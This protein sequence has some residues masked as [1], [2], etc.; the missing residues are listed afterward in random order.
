MDSLHEINLKRF[1]RTLRKSESSYLNLIEDALPSECK[2]WTTKD[3]TNLLDCLSDH[4]L[5]PDLTVTIATAF[6]PIL[7][8]LLERAFQRLLAQRFSLER[9][10]KLCAACAELLASFPDANTFIQKYLQTAPPVF[11]RLL[12]SKTKGKTGDATR[13][14]AITTRR[15]VEHS[16]EAYAGQWDWSPFLTLLGSKDAETRWHAT[17]TV[18]LISRMGGQC[19]QNF[20]HS[21]FK[22]E[23]IR[24][25]QIS[26]AQ[27]SMKA[28][29]LVLEDLT[30][31]EER[32]ETEMDTGHHLMSAQ[33]FSDAVVSVHGVLLPKLVGQGRGKS[34][35]HRLVPVPSTSRNLRSLALAVST[36]RAVLLEGPVGCGKTA[37]VEHLA[38][39]TGRT[40]PPSLTK[41]QLGDQTDSKA[42]L[43]TYRC[44]DI[45]GEFVWQPGALTQAV[46]QGHWI[47]LEDIDYAPMDVISVLL[48]LLESRTL[49]VPGH[50]NVI[51]AAPGFRLFATQRLLSSSG[52]LYRQQV[53]HGAMLDQL[54]TRVHVEPLSRDELHQVITDLY[55]KLTTVTSKLLNIYC[56]LTARHQ[57]WLD[58]PHSGQE[59]C[60]ETS[61]G[62]STS[63]SNDRSST[64]DLD[65]RSRSQLDL[66]SHGMR[67]VSTR[68]LIKWCE[69]IVTDFEANSSHTANRVFLEALDCFCGSLTTPEMRATVAE[70]IG[71]QVNITREKARFY[72]MTY[73]PEVKD[74]DS[75]ITA[76]RA[77]L[78]RKERDSMSRKMPRS[79]KF[80]FTRPAAVL[81]ERIACCI[82]H[83]EPVL[84]V[85]ET[86][87]GKTSTV[88]YLADLLGQRLRVINMNQQ[89]DSTDLL[90]GFKPVDLRQ[91]VAPVRE[92]FEDA[93]R[94]TFS[95]KQNLQFLSHIQQCFTQQRWRELVQ[96][97]SHSQQAA[98]KRFQRSHDK[99]QAGASKKDV[100][101]EGQWR[102]LGERLHQLTIQIQHSENALAFSFIE[103]TLVKALKAGDWILLD[104]I[105]LATAETLECLSSLLEGTEGS[106]VLMERGDT[107]PVVR[108]RDFRLFA[109]MN[110]ATDVGK[111]ELP[112]G[113]RNRFTEF[114]VDELEEVS[115]LQILTKSYLRA[116]SITEAQVKGIVQFYLSVR[117]EA[118]QKLTDGTGHRPHYSL[119]TLCR[120]LQL[121]SVNQCD[122]LPR[123]LYESF[124]LSFLT[125]L[126][127]TSHPVV[128]KL[129]CRHVIGRSNVKSLLG[130]SIPPPVGGGKYTKV[131]GY[132]VAVGEREPHQPKDYVITPAVRANLRDL[133]RIVSAG[134]FPVL[135]QGE[136]SVGKTSLVNYLA[137]LTG[138]HCV[139]VNNHEHTDLQE[140]IGFYAAD[141]SGKLVFK[142]GVLVDAMRRGHW[143]I[144]DE[145]NLAPS[146]VLEAL[147]RLLDDNRE[148]F[149]P[150]TQE[151][152]SA[153]PKF[154]LFATQNPP[155]QYGG[156][157]VLSRAFRN[158]FIE[159]HFDEIPSC[160]LETIL[161]DRCQ[162][163]ASYSRKMVAIMLELQMRRKGSGVFA[164][165]QGFITL[166][167]LF[168]WAERYRLANQGDQS[169][170]DWNQHLADEGFILLAGRV[171]RAEE[172]DTIRQV[173]Q[174]HFKRVVN[175]DHLFTLSKHTSPVTRDIL[176]KVSATTPTGFGHIVWTYGM[177]RL[178]V[179][180]GQALK[181]SEP[182]LLVGET[183][184]GKTTVCQLFAALANHKL[185]VVNCH[186]H[187]E[188][189]DFLGGLRPVRHHGNNNE[190]ESQKLFEWC[191]GPL[192]EAMRAG[193]IFLIDEISLADDSVLERLNSVLEPERTLLLAERG[194]GEARGEEVPLIRAEDGFRVVATMN[195]GGDFG[196][197]ELSP[198]LRNRF[199]E[200]WCT[201][202]KD[203]SDLVS[204]I[205]HN[206]LEGVQLCNQQDGTSGIG[207]AV[208]DFIEWFTNNEAGRK[209][210]VSI[211]DILS[212]VDFINV[213]CSPAKAGSLTSQ[214][215]LLP[216]DPAVAFIHG[217]CMVFVDGLGSG[218]TS[219]SSLSP[220]K[221]RQ[222][223]LGRLRDQILQ[224]TGQDIDLSH[225]MVTSDLVGEKASWGCASVSSD[226][227]WFGVEPFYIKCGPCPA[228]C[229]GYTL[230]ASTTALNAQ[231]LL[232]ALQLPRAV[233]LEG[234]P[235]VGKTSLVSALAR[236]SG[237]DLVRINLS[238]QT[239]ITDLFGADL[240]VEGGEGGQFAWRDGP[241]LQALKA[242]HWVVLDELN[243]ASQSVLEGL[244]A[245]LDHRAEIFVPELGRSFQIRQ[246][247]T[248]LFAC[249][250]PLRQGGGRKG[251][252]KSFLN[253][254]TQVYIEPFTSGDLLFITHSMYPM[255]DKETLAAMVEFSN[256]LYRETMVEGRWGQRG[257]PWEF[258]LRDLF[259]WCDLMVRDL[260]A[261]PDWWDP[262][263]HVGLVYGDRMRTAEDKE[264]VYRLYEKVLGNKFGGQQ[265]VAYRSSR[266]FHITPAWLQVG[267]AFLQR[268][269]SSGETSALTQVPLQLLHHDLGAMESIMK[270]VEMNWM[271]ILVGP[272]SSGKTSLVHLLAALTGH[273]LQVLAMNSA[274]DTT[275]L[276]GGFEQA[277][278]N[279]HWEALV[280]MVDDVAMETVR[281]LLTRHT[282]EKRK[283]AQRIMGILSALRNST[284][285]EQPESMQ[286]SEQNLNMVDQLLS[287]LNSAQV[288]NLSKVMEA[289][290]L[291]KRKYAMEDHSTPGGGGRFE[292]VDGLLVQALKQGDWLL[293]DNVN[294]CSPSVLDRLNGLLEP[295]G[296]LTINER[297]VIDGDI[298]AIKPHPEFRLFLAMDPR[299]GEISRAMRNRGVE[300]Y[301]LGEMEGGG[302]SNQDVC[303]LL[304]AIGL[305]SD[306]TCSTLMALHAEMRS[307]LHGNDSTRLPSLL[308]AASKTSR[309]VLNGL[310]TDRALREACSE[311]YVSSQL[312]LANKQRAKEALE[313]CLSGESDGI[314]S[315]ETEDCAMSVSAQRDVPTHLYPLTDAR[316][317][318]TSPSLVA[319]Q[320]Q[321]ALLVHLLEQCTHEDSTRSKPAQ[322]LLNAALLLFLEV[323]SQGDWELRCEWLKACG[324]RTEGMHNLSSRV[325]QSV[326]SHPL[327]DKIRQEISSEQIQ[328]FIL[329]PTDVHWN[330]QLLKSLKV[331]LER[332]LQDQDDSMEEAGDVE[333][334]VS[335][336]AQLATRLFLVMRRELAEALIAIEA[337]PG[338]KTKRKKP[339]S[340]L[341]WSNALQKGWLSVESLPHP[342]VSHV[343]PFLQAWDQFV[344]QGLAADEPL[345][346]NQAF[347]ILV[348][349]QWRDRLVRFCK[350]PIRESD[351]FSFG[352][353]ALHWDWFLKQTVR[354]V[355]SVLHKTE[356]LPVD[357]ETIMK[358][359]HA[360]LDEGGPSTGTFDLQLWERLT[361]SQ[362][363]PLPFQTAAQAQTR[364]QVGTLCRAMD[365]VTQAGGDTF[366]R[367]DVADRCV[368]WS[369]C[370]D[371]ALMRKKLLQVLAQSA[372]Y[373][374][375]TEESME[376]LEA[377]ELKLAEIG[378][379]TRDVTLVHGGEAFAP[380]P[381]SGT[382]QTPTAMHVWLWPIKE[383][384]AITTSQRVVSQMMGETFQQYGEAVIEDLRTLC[385][386]I[387]SQTPFNPLH[388]LPLERAYLLS[389][390]DGNGSVQGH[391]EVVAELVAAQLGLTWS[392][393]VLAMENWLSW[394]PLQEEEDD[395]MHVQQECSA[396]NGPANFFSPVQA[397]CMF[398]LLSD[399]DRAAA[400]PQ[401]RGARDRMTS[402]ADDGEKK[403]M[404]K[405]SCPRDGGA[406]KNV[407]LE[408][409][410]AYQ[411]H[412][413]ELAQILW[414][415][416]GWMSSKQASFL[417]SSVTYLVN[418][419]AWLLRAFASILQ[420]T[421]D[422][423]TWL[424]SCTSLVT[425]VTPGTDACLSHHPSPLDSMAEILR[426]NGG[427]SQQDRES[428]PLARDEKGGASKMIDSS[429]GLMLELFSG[430]QKL[431]DGPFSTNQEDELNG[432]HL[433]HLFCL[434]QCWVHLGHLQTHLLAPQGP[435]DPAERNAIKLEYVREELSDIRA[436]LRGRSISSSL[437]TGKP[438]EE[439]EDHQVHPRILA[440]QE[441]LKLLEE[442]EA[443]LSQKDAFRPRPP[444]FENLLRD[445]QLYLSSSGSSDSIGGLLHKLSHAFQE[446]A[447]DVSMAMKEER[448]WQSSQEHFV[449]RLQRDYPAYRDLWFGFAAGVMGA[450]YG[451]RLM[452]HSVDCKQQ[453][454]FMDALPP[455]GSPPAKMNTLEELLVALVGF[456]ST[457]SS[458]F[459]SSHSLAEALTTQGVHS[460]LQG[461][462]TGHAVQPSVQEQLKHSILKISLHHTANHARICGRLDPT[463][464]DLLQ[465]IL[466]SLVSHYHQAEQAAMQREEEEASLYKYKT[467]RHGDGM[468][469]EQKEEREL[470]E[471]F[472]SFDK[473]FNDLTAEPS[474]DDQPPQDLDPE[475]DQ[476]GAD[477][478]HSMIRQLDTAT[479]WLLRDTHGQLF[480]KMVSAG[481]L[482]EQGDRSGLQVDFANI[483][484]MGYS[485]GVQLAQDVLPFMAPSIDKHLVGAHLMRVRDLQVSIATQ[486]SDDRFKPIR[487][488]DGDAMRPYNIYHDPNIPEVVQCKSVLD[489]FTVRIDEL[490]AEWPD[491]PT[492]KQL[493]MLIQRIK[494]F[495]VNSPLMQFVTGLELLLARSQEWEANASRA[496]SLQ[497][498]LERIT[499]T[500]IR[501][502]KLELNCWAA[503]LD[504]VVYRQ[505]EGSL[506]WWFY[507]YRLVQS[508]GHSTQSDAE[509]TSDGDIDQEEGM[510]QEH[511]NEV[512]GV[513][514]YTGAGDGEFGQ[515]NECTDTIQGV[516]AVLQKLIEGANLGEFVTRV[517]ML[518]AFHC[519]LVAGPCTDKSLELMC[520]LWNLY[521]YYQQFL[522][523]VT[524]E[525]ENKRRPIEKELKDFVKI[526]KWNDISFWA[527][528]QAVEKTHKTLLKFSKKFQCALQE[529]AKAV[530]V[531]DKIASCPK[532]AESGVTP[533][534][535]RDDWMEIFGGSRNQEFLEVSSALDSLKLLYPE[536][537][538]L[539]RLP[540]L[541]QRMVKHCRSVVRGRGYQTMVST[542]DDFV[543]E[544]ISTLS[545]L[546]GLEVSKDADQEK[547][548]K[549][550]R[551]IHLR[552]RKALSELFKYL[553]SLGLSFK[554]GLM[555]R[556]QTNKDQ[557][558][559][560]FLLL[561]PVDLQAV[562]RPDEE[563]PVT[564]DDLPAIWA[565]GHQYFF[566][567]QARQAA[568]KSAIANP[569]KELGV[570][571][572]D[573]VKGFSEHLSD[574]TVEQRRE[575][576]TMATNISSLRTAVQQ[577]Q[578]I[579]TSSLSSRAVNSCSLPPQ[580]DTAAWIAR[581]KVMVDHSLEAVGQFDLLMDCCPRVDS[582]GEESD[583]AMSVPVP[584]KNLSVGS[585]CRKEDKVWLD[586]KASVKACQD[587][588]EETKSDLDP[589][590]VEQEGTKDPKMVTFATWNDIAVLERCHKKL[591]QVC[592][593]ITQVVTM[594]TQP[595]TG[596][597][598]QLVQSLVSISCCLSESSGEWVAWMQSLKAQ[599]FDTSTTQG[600]Q[601][602][603][604]W[605]ELPKLRV[606]MERAVTS[607]LLGIQAL[608]K[609]GQGTEVDSE[610]GTNDAQQQNKQDEDFSSDLEL[611]G[612]LVRK[613]VSGLSG[614][615]RSLE[616]AKVVTSAVS[617]LSV[618]HDLRGRC[619]TRQDEMV[620]NEC[621]KLAT[622]LIPMMHQYLG[623][624]CVFLRHMVAAHRA[625]SK[626]QSV[627]LAIFT[628]LASKG[629]CLPAEYSDEVG[630]EGATEF[631][632]IEGG[633]IGEGEGVKD[634]SDQIENEDQVEDTK[635]PGKEEKEKEDPNNQPDLEDEEHGIEMSDDFEGKLHDLDSKEGDQDQDE[636]QKDEEEQLDKQMGDVDQPDADKLD[637]RMWG[638]EEEE[639][640]DGEKEQKEQ[641]KEE[642]FGGGM[643]EEESRMVAKDDNQGDG[644][645]DDDNE[646]KK[647]EKEK[648]EE[649]PPD[650]NSLEPKD[651]SEFNDDEIDP[652]KAN[653]PPVAPVPEELDLPDDLEMDKDEKMEEGEEE[654]EGEENPLDIESKLD[655]NQEGEGDEN[656]GKEEE[657]D[658]EEGGAE[659]EKPEEPVAMETDEVDDGDEQERDQGKE[660]E[661]RHF[662]DK[663][664]TEGMDD[665]TENDDKEK[666]EDYAPDQGHDSEQQEAVPETMA[667]SR[668]S[669]QTLQP[670]DDDDAKNETDDGKEE[671]ATSA[672]DRSEDKHKSGTAER[673]QDEK[674]HEGSS[675]SKMTTL[676]QSGMQ[677]QQQAKK[678]SQSDSK[679]SLGSAEEKF[680]R[681]LDTV[682][683]GQGEEERTAEDRDEVKGE[684]QDLYEHLTDPTSHHDAQT[685]DAAT[686]DQMKEKEAVPMAGEDDGEKM[687][688]GDEERMEAEPDKE[689]E[690]ENMSDQLPSKKVAA[691]TGLSKLEAP[692]ADDRDTTAE[693]GDEDWM[694]P[695]DQ[696]ESDAMAT[697]GD[698]ERP[699]ESTI[700][701]AM[702]HLG[703]HLPDAVL[704][705]EEV[706]RLRREME[707]QL[708]LIG[709]KESGDGEELEAQ[710]MWQ[711]YESVT[712]ALARDLCEQL[713]LV[714]EPTQAS[715]LRGDFRT[716]K[717]LNMRKVI[718]YIASGFRKD[719]IW[720]RRTKP[721]KR[722]YQIMLAVDDS[723]SMADNRSR[724]LAFE[725]LAVISN[726]LTWLEAGQLAVCSFGENVQ[727]LHP[728]HEQFSEQSGAT[729][730]RQFTFAQKKTKIAQLLKYASAAMTT[731]RAPRVGAAGHPD[732]SQLLVVVSD[733]RGLFLEG[734]DTVRKA[735]RAARDANIFLMFVVIDNPENR[736]SILDI[737]VPIF[738]K[739]G[740]MP[741]IQS[742]MEHFPFPFY[743]ILRDI[744]ALP[745]TL[746]DALRQWFE[747]VT[748]A[749][750]S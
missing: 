538:I 70:V 743:I 372:V 556:N 150:E 599:E 124:C 494:S 438:L 327:V 243:L 425:M 4:L 146:D 368:R 69:R 618:V 670:D 3:R 348:A 54:W 564:M 669:Q 423:T 510:G 222:L 183:G 684:D 453:R 676:E 94:T 296:V 36:S 418:S 411:D 154:M 639:E 598:A 185:Q 224:L 396:L 242:G 357:L 53:S 300:I 295:G 89:S 718:P 140:Y 320:R 720:L 414:T 13:N 33:S 212:W 448:I 552:K 363:R 367:R 524:R 690:Q 163:P 441:R 431:L 493:S 404:R 492:L 682:D 315:M 231:R 621:A 634:V 534:N 371:G 138:N 626:M 339:T 340:V 152:V 116:Q 257:G 318:T 713:R 721:S 202:N 96:L 461:L 335:H 39:E 480:T 26:D 617:L 190:E 83:N 229:E 88:Q 233:L 274:M 217:A 262:G 73:K 204:I 428:L 141:E 71:G 585:L 232:R 573:R 263:L 110:P 597:T 666:G 575:I 566:R 2:V 254:F 505:S 12:Q 429:S 325:L 338:S 435:V 289:A 437:L 557:E 678:P 532:E 736:D 50:G 179:L 646:Q 158:R 238:E 380:A 80:A 115:D 117:K 522:P 273:R 171:R 710:K 252:P 332:A 565:S 271:T 500:I 107:K 244:N 460:L 93:F 486:Q 583:P 108:H 20:F 701:T 399:Q 451:M 241:L 313:R 661:K 334:R 593:R 95:V 323:A 393:T 286:L 588:L 516:I 201:Q 317:I 426:L 569:A 719:K 219:S 292:W 703:P 523:A 664:E 333:G 563:W 629:F 403:K 489:E 637:E 139:R 9:H 656:G 142:E 400:P 15:L 725:S 147:N 210:T 144:L 46:R 208:M 559:E 5:L 84:L 156:R 105:N 537:T 192:I 567:C 397:R 543:G 515:E 592:D 48:P 707:E 584:T 455:C 174:K 301:L 294:F 119:R 345:T 159:L 432:S 267:G 668:A 739:A 256:E 104:E 280:A 225:M 68:D 424:A 170:Y 662:E 21:L 577:L 82:S 465:G 81:V 536:S 137:Q 483:A 469:D 671:A 67:L 111:K 511:S 134:R 692:S 314:V 745:E 595:E 290:S 86:G 740:A 401:S 608:V 240:P 62:A 514:D 218:T 504:N 293:V 37:L 462:W 157:K 528:K 197:K 544:V 155:G 10:E 149:I 714:L 609:T 645:G 545:E 265:M 18:A 209:C 302:Y 447:D 477:A 686:D 717:R 590:A 78:Q 63:G 1:L 643:D 730:L 143:I 306:E 214:D 394:Q 658:A 741:E 370:Q 7:L 728:F 405:S 657:M 518:L 277:D 100:V 391:V 466:G 591:Q 695:D 506:K 40:G 259:R 362:G 386:Y 576:A 468:T 237:H 409:W 326:F 653:D 520:V 517:E 203:R 651:E 570:G 558:P 253:R 421:E 491:H 182:V 529:P 87:T 553:T 375:D 456:P 464:L 497:T 32:Q 43:G 628:D 589:L 90:G 245:C 647:T 663:D 291:L 121:A 99:E 535:W 750:K 162:I 605:S 329:S 58:A 6:S 169:F 358:R 554:K 145:L 495:S 342:V 173:L 732:T 434:G 102:S 319:V 708:A 733:G 24:H 614:D 607:V 56:L 269:K 106:L 450:R 650:P 309:L 42:L 135:I 118:I 11:E 112:P 98:C 601:T 349:L 279:R 729:I 625:C 458:D 27:D 268:Q 8:E 278:L 38:A 220:A 680:K 439:F 381:C 266:Q 60:S 509:V 25:H 485:A 586:I 507:V 328:S 188:T 508:Y 600:P 378:I 612:L 287:M 205:E 430:I 419:A 726:A 366:G 398:H 23:E 199:T 247:E 35:S 681:R 331:H 364:Q 373:P 303:T 230:A 457:L 184:C 77:K 436:E 297:G 594:F 304:R 417:N 64:S 181:F 546:Q 562:F 187:T 541:Y 383:H 127:R 14:V 258:N 502:R 689:E 604:Q 198:A 283:Q 611:D 574:L 351:R 696:A 28:P 151:V 376:L 284:T 75:T 355:V 379:L 47:L 250:N 59:G 490:L 699:T 555:L 746:S 167:D 177:R 215:D 715:K 175:P 166:R 249:Q 727:L 471:Q 164:G 449:A 377:V 694:P 189:S 311:V 530:F 487:K 683:P 547:Q 606:K 350:Q 503:M 642:E 665:D 178:A 512:A 410:E 305:K 226:W 61:E 474:L 723:S 731:A 275:E 374:G 298:P 91:V 467:R 31:D 72:C 443:E 412:L 615:Q 356:S 578:S 352:Q 16:P 648:Q 41:V 316:H 531:D 261:R 221:A 76:G 478:D 463:T 168:R 452:A 705:P 667:K 722:Q 620:F 735:V 627:L 165:K 310:P 234:S 109:C 571:N 196:K 636:N 525:M 148:L 548:R 519:Q 299:H 312:L 337:Q 640:E 251:L 513:R 307:C 369:A 153:H 324:S 101:L 239:D 341:D 194:S 633:G 122:S 260:G 200:V 387:S 211:R 228:S 336:I 51:K 738:S 619:R 454:K 270:C 427:R 702:E 422:R 359:L 227:K 172:E 677:E 542:L 193:S 445:T 308:L 281:S 484:R 499:Q 206:L 402:S 125:Q 176:E 481:W 446:P 19:R 65:E 652:S 413:K 276:L 697:E 30:S 22:E 539:S 581:S 57:A 389:P 347:Q 330:Q 52:G 29:S 17:C 533:D 582:R 442:M 246:G 255:I 130:Q 384:L 322:N 742:Y 346:E 638:D 433:P 132:W 408:S 344:S 610:P 693:E 129:V 616:V 679:R 700:H 235:G 479:M 660:E 120:A 712:S 473:E 641:K 476:S 223:C 285:N 632:D 321:G 288:S 482:P 85:G 704:D 568:L 734:M 213:C 49:S 248:R 623:L 526:A 551:H 406:G 361:D 103:G 180:V 655:E 602:A 459:Q 45:P 747:L 688:E 354:S 706:E 186:L 644:E 685:M 55:P 613:I 674:G 392:N 160:E 596:E 74:L 343:G 390:S 133:A 711:S 716:G 622:S 691:T 207:N 444:L 649:Q 561:P 709:S 527:M 407:P 195:P 416:A 475:A 66:V 126:D 560:K 415:N 123:S 587:L 34:P 131:E 114:Y 216:V 550:I 92:A 749:D 630:G 420:D 580:A 737:R 498:H 635:T 388:L 748:A 672:E 496:V 501:W 488:G 470:R 631:E 654:G 579:H 624:A 97:M 440:T 191:D 675:T 128:E 282:G 44:T 521:C 395:G 472:P 136:T 673:R 353:L 272:S 659:P 360:S 744:N 572:I 264:K 540:V 549:E 382:T 603:D 687:E 385:R 113:I 724:R 236:A 161:H 365:V 698:G 79:S